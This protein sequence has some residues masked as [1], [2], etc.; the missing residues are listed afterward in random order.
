MK[1]AFDERKKETTKIRAQEI[2]LNSKL[3]DEEARLKA[4]SAATL[5]NLQEF[6]ALRRETPTLAKFTEEE[7]SGMDVSV[8]KMRREI[9]SLS[10]KKRANK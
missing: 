2:D 7:L 6:E 9:S 10:S 1:K 3:S 5:K 4:I 8:D